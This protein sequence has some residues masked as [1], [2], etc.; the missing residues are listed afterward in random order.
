MPRLRFVSATFLIITLVPAAAAAKPFRYPEGKFGKGELKY[1]HG[2]PVLTVAGSPE[3]MGAQIGRLAVK[4]TP[5]LVTFVKDFLKLKGLDAFWPNLVKTG[6]GMVPQFPADARAELEA[7][8][9]A[10]GMGRDYFIV[11]STLGDYVKL[12]GCS[13]LVVGPGRS[14]GGTPLFGR[15]L[16]FPPLAGLHEYSLVMVYRPRGKHAF[17]SVGFPGLVGCISGINDAGLCLAANE[18]Y[19]A[20]DGSPRFDRKGVPMIM[21]F[22]RVMEECRTVAEAEQLIRSIK[23]TT[24]VLLTVCDRKG[25]AVFEITPKTVAVRRPVQDVCCCT[26]HFR[27]E[28]LAILTNCRRYQAL[29]RTRTLAKVGLA[30]IAKKLDEVNQGDCTMQTMIFEPAALKLHVSIGHCPSSKYPL[31]KLD[32]ANWLK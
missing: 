32:L 14:A 12:G 20:A 28:G 8:A 18:V 5:R 6:T 7:I 30:Q 22:R 3:E 9:R 4:P 26:N 29:R 21:A 15:N 27:V 11:T 23:R 13:T 31:K 17:A 25:G 2:V 10:S 16:D 19:A 1:V 24:A